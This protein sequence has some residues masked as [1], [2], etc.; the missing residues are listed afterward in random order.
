MSNIGI[1]HDSHSLEYR[2]PFGA[3]KSNEKVVLKI[4]LDKL[5]VVYINLSYFDGKKEELQ[6]KLTENT[7]S[8]KYIFTITLDTTNLIGIIN[9]YFTIAY[10]FNNNI[11]YGNN[12]EALG[13]VGCK[14]EN[15]PVPY[16]ITV[17]KERKVPSWYKEGI[18]YQIFVDR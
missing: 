3:V 9:Y 13:G 15:H 2:A 17:F 16:Q 11:Y 12:N 8:D 7:E 5:A 4:L 6:M 14:Y 10:D 18:I 1:F